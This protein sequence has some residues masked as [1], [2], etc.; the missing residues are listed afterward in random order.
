MEKFGTNFPK[1]EAI[2]IKDL[3]FVVV[4]GRGKFLIASTFAGLGLTPSASTICPRNLTLFA[5]KINFFGLSV[6][7]ASFNAFKTVES[8]I[9]LI[10]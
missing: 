8:S 6:S 2:P 10:K 3:N 5:P 1:K 4:S 7:P 9:M